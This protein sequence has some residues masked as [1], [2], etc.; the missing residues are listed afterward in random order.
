MLSWKPLG[1]DLSL[2][3]LAGG[4]QILGC[5]TPVTVS[6]VTG[7]SPLCIPVSSPLLIGYQSLNLGPSLIQYDLI[8]TI[9]M[10]SLN[11]VTLSG[12]GWTGIWGH[13]STHHRG[14]LWCLSLC[15]IYYSS[16]Q[17]C[18]QKR[19]S[20]SSQ[21]QIYHLSCICCLPS[22]PLQSLICLCVLT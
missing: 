6:I 5:I 4:S 10:L 13:Y 17:V 11:K 15:S 8:L 18:N 12:S 7:P 1:K 14:H 2:T 22:L 20:T 21:L 3:L 19:I 9:K 16:P